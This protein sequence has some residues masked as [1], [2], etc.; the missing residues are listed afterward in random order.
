VEPSIYAETKRYPDFV[1]QPELLI[2]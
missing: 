1:I 2:F